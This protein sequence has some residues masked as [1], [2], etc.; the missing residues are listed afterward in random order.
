MIK[1]DDICAQTVI[2]LAD[3]HTNGRIHKGAIEATMVVFPYSYS[4]IQH[5][6]YQNHGFVLNPTLYKLD[7]FDKGKGKAGRPC[8]YSGKDFEAIEL[9]PLLIH[10]S[11]RIV[12]IQ[13]GITYV[14]VW[15]Y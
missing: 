8:K 14:T 10:T 12:E 13:I 2:F 4:G 1:R 9:I 15:C 11:L 3:K 5:V 7:V 6:L